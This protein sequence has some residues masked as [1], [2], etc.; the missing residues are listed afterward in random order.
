MDSD[1][2]HFFVDFF[3]CFFGVQDPAVLE[4]ADADYS[5]SAKVLLLSLPTVEELRRRCCG[6]A[7]RPVLFFVFFLCFFC[8]FV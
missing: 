1:F 5:Y 3:V 7:D 6:S 2:A 4:P 8:L